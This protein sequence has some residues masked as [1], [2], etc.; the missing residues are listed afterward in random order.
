MRSGEDIVIDSHTAKIIAG[1][2]KIHLRNLS[3]IVTFDEEI[4]ALLEG[5]YKQ[6]KKIREQLLQLC[7]A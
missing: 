3:N 7:Y 2:I 6:A 4:F 1:I 5:E